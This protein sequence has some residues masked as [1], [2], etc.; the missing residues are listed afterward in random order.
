MKAMNEPTEEDYY[1]HIV[2]D[3][4]W[5]DNYAYD[6]VGS[7]E[8]WVRYKRALERWIAEKDAEWNEIAIDHEHDRER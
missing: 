4:E 7:V 2:S 1:Q 5:G 3:L 6:H 8:M